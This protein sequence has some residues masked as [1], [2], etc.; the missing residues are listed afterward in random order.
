MPNAES[1]PP[2]QSAI[3]SATH[4]T[5]AYVL[6]ASLWIALSDRTLELAVSDA[7][8]LSRL[9]TYKGWLFVVVTAGFLFALTFR[10][11]AA[12]YAAYRHSQRSERLYQSLVDALPQGLYRIDPTGRI[13]FANRA[14]LAFIG[15]NLE[16]ALGKPYYELY[17]AEDRIRYRVDDEKVLA[18]ETL[19]KVEEIIVPTSGK[20]GFIEVVI[21]PLHNSDGNIVGIQGIFW[22]VSAHKNAESRVEYLVNH[23]PL[24]GLPNRL[25]L[26]DRFIQATHKADREQDSV[27]MLFIDIDRLKDVNDSLGHPVGDQLLRSIAARMQG[28]VH[29]TDTISRYGG[30]AFVAL[31][32]DIRTH[33]DA[34]RIAERL[35]ASVEEPL[36]VGDLKL[37]CSLSIGIALY[38]DDGK[39]FDSLMQHAETAMYQV[40]DAGRNGYRV[41][42]K[43]MNEGLR[44]R[45]DLQ[46]R[47]HP[48][49]HTGK[50]QLH[51]Q[52]QFDLNDG[53]LVGAEALLR[54]HDPQLGWIPPAQFIPIAEDT[55]LIVNI[56]AWVI[57]DACRQMRCWLD[58]GLPPL[59]VAVNL[60]PRQFS[61]GDPVATVANALALYQIDGAALELELTES[62]LIRDNALTDQV[63]SSFK[64][65]GV[66]L[67]IDDFGTGYSNLGYL[68]HF[69]FDKLKIDQS[70][71]R[72][73]TDD[74]DSTA[75]VRSIIT[76]A[77]NL[78]LQTLAEGVETREQA[79]ALRAF[80]CNL[81]QGYYFGRPQPALDFEQL[82]RNEAL[83][84]QQ[85]HS[86]STP[87][88]PAAQ[89]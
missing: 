29:D 15:M 75:I 47:L 2:P 81:V 32:P 21:T 56:G 6:L 77:D 74:P 67:A 33:L 18:G 78:Q 66:G 31:I 17:P 85:V 89:A 24:T 44:E 49:F 7:A 34:C 54:W 43:P 70:F 14:A 57:A 72:D 76:I 12:Q 61:N 55:G 42:A 53:R 87:A 83:R 26:Q 23:D 48:A 36:P 3:R 62:M 20:R 88:S 79:D 60:S 86:G 50:L 19:H 10:S 27:G 68:K 40:K 51:Y 13:T 39:D 16:Q 41:Y 4:I 38:P 80:G 58:A 30:D 65:L 82:L 11:L 69:A 37:P 9:Q 28:S 25:L 46:H 22:D 64:D 73:M 8:A 84:L 71:V 45:L 63:L 1:P 52:P 5:L 35:L 59:T